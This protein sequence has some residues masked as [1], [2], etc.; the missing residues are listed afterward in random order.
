MFY[1]VLQSVSVTLVTFLSSTGKTGI[2][3]RTALLNLLVLPVAF[4]IGGLPGGITGIALAWAAAYLSWGWRRRLRATLQTL[5]IRLLTFLRPSATRCVTVTAMS[6]WRAR[7]PLAGAG[8][9]T[10][11][12]E[13]LALGLVVAVAAGLGRRCCAG[14]AATWSSSHAAAAKHRQ[15]F[16]V[17]HG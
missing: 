11:A 8:N 9:F 1:A 17:G 10:S 2:A 15:V 14:S 13:L 16:R 4:V 12:V 7:L 3:M 6:L 5:D